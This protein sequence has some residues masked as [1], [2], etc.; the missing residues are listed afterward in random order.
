MKLIYQYIW[1][2]AKV[3]IKRNAYHQVPILGR[4]KNLKSVTY[5][6]V[7]GNQ[8]K[9]NKNKPKTWRRKDIINKET[10]LAEINEVRKQRDNE[11]N[12]YKKI[13]FLE[14]ISKTYKSLV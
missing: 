1:D 3:V 8:K 13:W 7:S 14:K 12:L 11:E 6:F 2:I 4:K 5:A 9:K 10:K